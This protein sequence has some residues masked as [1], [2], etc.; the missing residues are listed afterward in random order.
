MFN[1]YGDSYDVISTIGQAFEIKY[2][3][4]LTKHSQDLPELEPIF[5]NDR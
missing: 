2:K 4:V 1:C 5:I 3:D